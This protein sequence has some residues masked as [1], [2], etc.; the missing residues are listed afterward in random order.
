MFEAGIEATAWA[1]TST[2]RLRLRL[3]RCTVTDVNIIIIVIIKQTQLCIMSKDI[4]KLNLQWRV[5]DRISTH[6]DQVFCHLV[7]DKCKKW[8]K[9]S[10]VIGTRLKSNRKQAEAHVD[11]D[12]CIVLVVRVDEGHEKSKKLTNTRQTIW[13]RRNSMMDY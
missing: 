4:N 1:R 8:L 9:S 2:L 11:H 12:V 10:D 3:Y 5:V 7:L 6:K 13:C